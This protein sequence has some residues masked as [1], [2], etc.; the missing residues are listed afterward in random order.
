[1]YVSK[2]VYLW[3][4]L[5]SIIVIFDASYVLL[6]PHSL[7]G[8]KYE[9]IYSP[10]QLYIKF[11]TLYGDNQDPFNIIQSWLNLV[12]I[13]LAFLAVFLSLCPHKE[14]KLKGAFLAIIVSAFTFWK[15]VL[16]VWYD[17]PFLSEETLAFTADSIKIFYFPTSFWI[18]CP[19]W[20]ILSVSKRICNEI[21]GAEK[22]KKA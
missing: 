17:H 11:D 13:S 18:I 21:L 14:V 8:G 16:Y 15:T 12:E 6:R 20:T 9:D 7:K 2:G 19:V 3:L 22:K 1:M 5:S 10:Y 4:I